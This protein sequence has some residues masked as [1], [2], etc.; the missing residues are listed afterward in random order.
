MSSM[1]LCHAEISHGSKPVA[2]EYPQLA[3]SC[4]RLIGAG[5]QLCKAISALLHL[6]GPTGQPRYLGVM[7]P[8]LSLLASALR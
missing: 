1:G 4:C 5:T 6:R 7:S 8:S 3:H 2:R